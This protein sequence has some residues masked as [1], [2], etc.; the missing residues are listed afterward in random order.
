MHRTQVLLEDDQYQRLKAEAGRTGRS[1]G[2]LVRSA[3]D[4]VYL[5]ARQD[6]LVRALDDSFGA[7]GEDEFDGL[8]GEGYVEAHRTGLAS[9]W[10]ER[11]VP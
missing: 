3:V 2:D 8:D 10:S 4:R 6:E 5:S 11:G 1:I 9:R 7:A